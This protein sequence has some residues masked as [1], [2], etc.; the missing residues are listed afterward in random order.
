MCASYIASRPHK[1]SQTLS[2]RIRAGQAATLARTDDLVAL[3]LRRCK[4]EVADEAEYEQAL[5]E[6]VACVVARQREYG[7]DIVNDGE[8]GHSL[9]YPSDYGAWWAYIFQR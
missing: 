4:G 8:D 2:A 7:I 5:A 3:T 9:G 1:I 6:A